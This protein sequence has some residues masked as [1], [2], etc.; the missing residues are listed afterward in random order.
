M[1]QVRK[2]YRPY[3]ETPTKG[4]TMFKNRE[5]RV[6]IAKTDD[7]M[8]ETVREPIVQIS[9]EDV[10]D[11]TNGAIKNIAIAVGS[12]IAVAATTDALKEIAI[13]HGTK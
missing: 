4:R 11:V 12:I 7:G 9:K 2:I 8:T 6:R 3:N 1:T 10:I 5:F 13:H